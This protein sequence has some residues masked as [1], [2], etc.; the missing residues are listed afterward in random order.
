MAKRALCTCLLVVATLA[1]AG[2]ANAAPLYGTEEIVLRAD[3]SFNGASGTPNPFID[4]TLTATVTSPKGRVYTVH[5]FFDGDGLGNA[6]G[7]VFKVR[8]SA[9]ELG[10]WRWRT[11]SNNP[12]LNGKSGSFSCS[13]TL[14][15]VFKS[16][17]VIENPANLRTFKYQNGAPVYLLGKF[18]DVAAPDPL[19]YSHTFLSER[20]T[21]ANRQA[22][23][24]RHRGMGLNKIN[25]YL[26]NRG[27]Y[28][29][30]A[31]TPWVGF[32]ATPDRKRFDLKR[33]RTYDQWIVKLRDAGMVAHL[34]FFADDSG[35]GDLTE[36]DRK[37]LIRYAMAR[38]SG[39]SNTMFVLALEWQEG[40][41][42]TEVHAHANYLH[43]H[44]PWA[45]LASV[46]GTT[47]NFSYPT[48]SWA[49]YMDI[50]AGNG[51]TPAS[52]HSMG[53]HHRGLAAKPLV[54]EEHGLGQ[55]DTVHRQRAWAAFTAGAGGSGTG[56][57]LKQLATFIARVRFER[58]TPSDALVTSK[59]GWALA[60]KNVA[61]VVYLPN[62]GTLQADLAGATGTFVAEWFD[63][64]TGAWRA[65]PAATG[66]GVRTFTPPAAGDWAL[67]LHR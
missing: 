11:T 38:L 10:T 18:L 5:G 49:D 31:T 30:V 13:G 14:A 67:F 57:F 20:L 60:E 3:R 45:R 37:L 32:P 55:E 16:G 17:P 41:A 62:G 12:G 21:D 19:K 29:G 8:V 22:M 28:N 51:A 36:A 4:V 50:Q 15:S 53:L 6:N 40:W 33:W 25:V 46:H 54:Q 48:A 26:A 58:M 63:P 56:S 9:D 2:A 52:V 66:G 64:R 39:Y 43:Q 59:N 34:W 27:D 44:N 23:L 1:L 35:F 61:Y 24:D 7:N 65:A 47:G 42:T